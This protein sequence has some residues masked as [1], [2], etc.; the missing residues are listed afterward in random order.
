MSSTVLLNSSHYQNGV[1]NYKFNGIQNIQGKEIA[2]Q[3]LSFYNSFFNVSS[4][5]T[6]SLS[7]S[8][9]IILVF[10]VFTGA[11]TYVM[12]EYTLSLPS[13]FYT[14]T[15]FNNAVQNFCLLN[16]LYMKDP[17]TG[18][19]LYFV[20]ISVNSPVYRIEIDVYYIPTSA[21]ATT[22]GYTTGGMVLNTGN[23]SV[24][25][26]VRFVST[27]PL[28][29]FGYNTGTYPVSPLTSASATYIDEAATEILGQIPPS[30]NQITALTLRCNLVS[31][32]MSYPT[33]LLCQ[34]PIS[35]QFGA[36]DSFA[37]SIA[38]YMPIVDG[39][40][41]NFQIV[42]SD[43]NQNQ[44]IPLDPEITIALNI[45][46]RAKKNEPHN[47]YFSERN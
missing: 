33:D 7:V 41:A 32:G 6:P 15:D 13:G 45:R 43:Q 21:Q 37:P 17:A 29:V 3:Q 24:A 16:G 12:T 10:P 44:I 31:D 39:I 11:N 20:D 40:Y 25:P 34:A 23:L 38:C 27:S 46:D 42:F 1:M 36:I 5:Q 47:A 4:V 9:T 35:A 18:L 19:N 2:V 30:E 26:Q 22:L 8:N 14:Y 28:S